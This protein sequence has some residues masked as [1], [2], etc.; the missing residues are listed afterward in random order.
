MTFR[1]HNSH[2]SIGMFRL[3]T[4]L[5]IARQIYTYSHPMICTGASWVKYFLN[6]LKSDVQSSKT[7]FDDKARTGS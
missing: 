1:D 5:R 4:E 3:Q 7:H 6:K 2:I